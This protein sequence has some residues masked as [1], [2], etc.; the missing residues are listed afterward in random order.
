M[1]KILI[2]FCFI[3]G[4]VILCDELFKNSFAYTYELDNSILFYKDNYTDLEKDIA[5]YLEPIDDYIISNS[6]F[7][8]DE[9]LS[10]NYDFLINFA[11]DYVKEN[12]DVY[13][14]NIKSYEECIYLN[15]KGEEY[16]T[17]S[18]VEVNTIYEIIDRYFGVRD[19]SI[20]NDNVCLRDNYISLSDYSDNLFLSDIVDVVVSRNEDKMLAEVIYSNNDKY[21][22]VF[23]IYNNVLKLEN[24]EVL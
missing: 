17:F 19:F 6:S 14:D 1:R 21:L 13:S 24:I 18:Y 2:C 3:F 11:L 5:I 22:Y 16:N 7:I 10:N 15:G 23:N 8:Y 4:L 20:L 9:S 12:F